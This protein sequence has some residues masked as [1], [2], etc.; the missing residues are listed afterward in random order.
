MREMTVPPTTV[1]LIHCEGVYMDKD[2][3]RV[4]DLPSCSSLLL[5][6]TWNTLIHVGTV[7]DTVIVLDIE[8]FHNS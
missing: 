8:S 6:H 5:V 4:G 7:I 2:D 1:A 3:M